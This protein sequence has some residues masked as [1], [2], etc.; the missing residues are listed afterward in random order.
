MV[1]IDFEK[2]IGTQGMTPISYTY[3]MQRLEWEW[4][5]PSFT[6]E[7]QVPRIARALAS[8]T[9]RLRAL[10]DVAPPG[11]MVFAIASDDLLLRSNPQ[12]TTTSPPIDVTGERS[13]LTVVPRLAPPL[14][15]DFKRT[16]KEWG[17][18]L[19]VVPSA[20]WHGRASSDSTPAQCHL[21]IKLSYHYSM[22]RPEFG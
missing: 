12:L 20:L 8:D 15:L 2:H 22:Y 7:S 9:K 18:Q 21:R 6:T 14:W 10:I 13:D 1:R 5:L 3:F 17:V 4:N 11:G 16:I 19:Y